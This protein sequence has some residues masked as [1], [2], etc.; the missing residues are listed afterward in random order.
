LVS[1]LSVVQNGD[2]EDFIISSVFKVCP[3][4]ESFM[5]FTG[6]DA[7]A[8]GRILA[9]VTVEPGDI[10]DVY[11]ERREEIEVGSGGANGDGVPG[12]ISR[13]EQG[14]AVRLLRKEAAWLATRDEFAP[15][16]IGRALREVARTQPETPYSTP[17]KIADAFDGP[18]DAPEVRS[19][20]SLVERCVRKD[21]V[22]FPLKLTVGRHRRWMQV[23]GP[24]LVSEPESESFYSV[25]A[26]LPWGCYGALRVGLGEGA[27][28]A[29]AT[30]L[31]DYFGARDASLP[32]AGSRTLVLGPAAAAVLLH[33]AVA[34]ALEADTLALS[35]LPEAACG[36]E[37]GSP[38]LNVLDDPAGSADPVARRFDDEGVP[39]VRRWLLKR[40]EVRE[41]LADLAFARDSDRLS[42]GAG[43]RA[44]RHSLPAPR[45]THLE[46]V[47]GEAPTERLLEDARGG[48][49]LPQAE[50]G[51]LDPVAGEFTLEFPFGREI[52]SAGLADYVGP[53]RLRGRIAQ[54]LMAIA[55]IGSE[56]EFAGAGWCAKGGQRMAVWATSPAILVEG[57]GIEA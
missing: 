29:V 50:R 30:D 36:Y 17:R 21:H 5:P 41:P 18:V 56:T 4:G 23:V 35:G 54:L 12:F 11:L 28:E 3:V 52:G 6:L 39:V 2:E 10:A 47:P 37:I 43:R 19:F 27:A 8:L 25:R 14:F 55:A 20:P 44:N 1:C 51:R 22:A 34:H 38:L 24:R 48:L 7:S 53:S 32:K 45:S 42:P 49:Y 31:V 57:L 13:R 26:D 15:E 46:L 40:G 9:Q 33:E 16:E